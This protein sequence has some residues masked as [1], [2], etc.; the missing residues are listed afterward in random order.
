MTRPS[1]PSIRPLLL[2]LTLAASAVGCLGNPT[3]LVRRGPPVEGERWVLFIGNSHTYVENVPYL[4]REIAKQGGD[5]SI[6][7]S[8]VTEPNFSLEDHWYTGRAEQALTTYTWDY[9]VMQQG[10]SATG[11]NP[12]HLRFWSQQFAALIREAGATPV[13]YQIWPSAI[14]RFDAEGTLTSYSAAAAS[15]SGIL[16]PAGDGFTAAL[17]SSPSAGVYAADGTHASVRGAYVAALTIVGRLTDID[18]LTLPP[19]IPGRAEDELVVRALQ[20]AAA[21]ALGRTPARP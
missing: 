2:A 11:E 20:Q 9:V 6:R 19:V 13:L 4:V 18:V 1:R 17:E 21:T 5:L 16:A 10:P 14:R 3:G 8:S 12:L 15:V 7:T